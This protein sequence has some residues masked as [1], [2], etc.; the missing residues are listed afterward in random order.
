MTLATFGMCAH[1]AGIAVEKDWEGFL[2]P[3]SKH[4]QPG[5]VILEMWFLQCRAGSGNVGYVLQQC[6]REVSSCSSK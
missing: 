6:Q 5:T 3:S 2:G 4:S 1:S